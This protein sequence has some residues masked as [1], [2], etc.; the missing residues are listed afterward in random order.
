MSMNT[1]NQKEKSTAG[2]K[3]PKCSSFAVAQKTNTKTVAVANVP[4]RTVVANPRVSEQPEPAMP[5]V[6]TEG[7]QS[8]KFN[9]K[10]LSNMGISDGTFPSSLTENSGAISLAEASKEPIND[11][12]R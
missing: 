11:D 6:D 8:G 2:A 4:K 9:Q 12:N 7:L 1:K 10:S 3:G 5:N